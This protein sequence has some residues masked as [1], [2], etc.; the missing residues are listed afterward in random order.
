M[1]A[2]SCLRELFEA[3]SAIASEDNNASETLLPWHV[4][5]R[6]TNAVD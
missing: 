4:T 2:H 6:H 5:A 1:E 3:L